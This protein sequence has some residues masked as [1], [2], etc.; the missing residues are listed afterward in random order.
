MADSLQAVEA[1]LFRIEARAHELRDSPT[2]K[3]FCASMFF[4]QIRDAIREHSDEFGSRLEVVEVVSG[5]NRELIR[6]FREWEKASVR[7]LEES[8][9]S[10]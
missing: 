10:E 2:G 9:F 6:E 3:V 1:A 7:E 5:S 4:D 8:D